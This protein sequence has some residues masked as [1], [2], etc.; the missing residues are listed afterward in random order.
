MTQHP[1]LNMNPAKRAL[2]FDVAIREFVTHGF[3]QASLN[4]IIAEVKMSKSSFYHYFANKTELFQQILEQNLAPFAALLTGFDMGQLTAKTFWPSLMEASKNAT[5]MFMEN[6]QILLLGRMFWK[7]RENIKEQGMTSDILEMVQ[8]YISGF[9]KRGQELGV[10]RD[11]LPVSFLINSVMALGVSM[12]QWVLENFDTIA[13]DEFETF[14]LKSLDI[15]IRLL[16][17]DG[18]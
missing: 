13:Q 12:D 17:P 5:G 15:F 14:N 9:L 7:S 18:G 8:D 10:V 3:S 2:L 11:D 6:P 16:K 4:R 1:S